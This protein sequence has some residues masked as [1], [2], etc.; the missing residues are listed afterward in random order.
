MAAAD[1]RRTIQALQRRKS[2]EI[3]AI[4]IQRVVRGQAARAATGAEVAKRKVR[5]VVGVAPNRLAPLQHWKQH[6][7]STSMKHVC[8]VHARKGEVLLLC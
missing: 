1:T 7:S 3:A 5:S 4:S 8:T 2:A 6:L